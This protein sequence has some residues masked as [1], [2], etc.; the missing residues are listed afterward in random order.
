M[1]ALEKT[2]AVNPTPLL[3]FAAK[4]DFTAENV[5]FLIHVKRWRDAWK[6]APRERNTGE[7]TEQARAKLFRM[8]VDMY[9]ADLYEQTAD[10]PINVESAI[11]KSMD[12][13]FGPAV[14][15]GKRL[16][17]STWDNV[18]AE[19]V[20][21]GV[22]PPMDLDQIADSQQSPW[23][24]ERS[25]DEAESP[26]SPMEETTNGIVF[27]TNPCVAPLGPARARIPQDFHQGIF[28]AAEASIK[29]LVLTNTWCRFVMSRSNVSELG[30][31][32]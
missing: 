23:G 3:Y 20:A 12:N 7:V 14:P 4:Q 16:D 29:Y 19:N 27:E 24:D 28:D 26:V 15:G 22:A 5:I 2:L 9:M 6:T 11:R 30:T 32:A 17:S 21:F 25:V 18:D 1:A 10:F 31:T 13:T 8:A